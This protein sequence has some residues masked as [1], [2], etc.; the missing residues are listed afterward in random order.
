MADW[1]G[2][3]R[4]NYFKVK[5][6]IAFTK[7]LEGLDVEIHAG[8]NGRVCLLA[9][10]DHGSW[11]SGRFDADT[12]EYLDVDVVDLVA[13]HLAPGEVAVL[14]EVGAEKLRYLT[15]W[16]IAIN[17]DGERVEVSIEDIY[18]KAVAAF[19][20]TEITQAAY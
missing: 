20:V 6:I 10:G 13:G 17:S 16:A 4:S 15:G 9:M 11:P 12:D 5:D 2:S 7:A 8:D 3:A 19:G 1:N 18:G 14:Q